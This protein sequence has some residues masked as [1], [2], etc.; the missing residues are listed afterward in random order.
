MGGGTG[1]GG[2]ADPRGFRPSLSMDEDTTSL[3]SQ[4]QGLFAVLGFRG[5]GA[6][7]RRMNGTFFAID[8]GL[9]A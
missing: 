9:L 2:E 4:A 3:Q 5:K 7:D 1:G 6:L 8:R